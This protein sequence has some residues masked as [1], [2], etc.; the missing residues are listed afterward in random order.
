MIRVV[1]MSGKYYG[2]E[3]DLDSEQ[4]IENIKTFVAEGTPFILVDSL[5]DLERFDISEDEV[6]MVNKED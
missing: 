4:E 1:K 6:I 2:I 5:E 3:S